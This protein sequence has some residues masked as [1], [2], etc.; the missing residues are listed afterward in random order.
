MSVPVEL[1]DREM[2]LKSASTSLNS[3]VVSLYSS[4]IAPIVV[5]AVL[6]VADQETY[7]VDLKDIKIIRKLEYVAAG[8]GDG[9]NEGCECLLLSASRSMARPT[10]HPHLDPFVLLPLAA[11]SRTRSWCRAWSSTSAS[12]IPFLALTA[13]RRP[14]L[15]SCSFACRRPRRTCVGGQG[16]AA[17][18]ARSH[19]V[20]P[21]LPSF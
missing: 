20:M 8:E 10:L 17:V 11:R 14:R 9:G 21:R 15:P 2:L 1:S 19:S 4:T 3:K 16:H 6:A 7:S 18:T 12:R 5:D 13:W